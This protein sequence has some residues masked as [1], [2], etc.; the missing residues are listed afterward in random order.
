MNILDLLG[1]VMQS[2]MSPSSET[3]MRNVVSSGTGARNPSPGRQPGGLEEIL[4][5]I[6]GSAEEHP[7]DLPAGRRTG[8]LGEILGMLSGSSEEQTEVPSRGLGINQSAEA[9]GT[10]GEILEKAGQMA[11]G[12]QNLALG[13]LGALAGALMGGGGARSVGGAMGGGAMAVFGAMAFKALMG[14]GQS[15]PQVPLGLRQ[16]QSEA[17][18]QELELQT[19]LVLRAM[20]NAAK[21]DGR[22]DDGEIGRIVGKMQEKGASAEEQRYVMSLMQKPMETEKIVAA[23][24][25]KQDLGAEMYA[26]SLMAIEVDTQAE[27]AYLKNLALDLGLSSRVA[28]QIEE[29]AGV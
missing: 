12:K 16:P 8:G 29:M 14:S 10:F 9:G 24:G 21:S 4:G 13:G 11:G 5:M 3:R 7:G 27:R 20:I 2:E 22:I 19:E 17:D 6:T 18:R 26:A 1:T 25:G 23:A 15:S 28:R